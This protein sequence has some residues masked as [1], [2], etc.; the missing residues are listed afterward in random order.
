MM[1]LSIAQLLLCCAA[2]SAAAPACTAP[3][4]PNAPVLPRTG[5]AKDLPPPPDNVSLKYIALGFG[6]QNYTCHSRGSP[7]V[8]TG[9]LAMLYNITHLYP[10][11]SFSSLSPSDFAQVPAWALAEREPPLN[12]NTSGYGRV[13]PSSPGASLSRPFPPDAPLKLSGL[14]LLPFLGHHFFDAQGVPTFILDHG[15]VQ[16]PTTKVAGVPPPTNADPGP[17]GTGAVNWLYLG[18]KPGA[19]GAQYVYRVNTAGGASHGCDT[20][21]GDDSTSYAATYWFY[22]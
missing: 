8:A 3:E 9:A 2:L 5:N 15:R 1:K 19:V 10:H 20:A 16:L 18:P 13:D 11:Q 7:P 17:Q 12:R 14:P 6:I 4:T 22:G 21:T